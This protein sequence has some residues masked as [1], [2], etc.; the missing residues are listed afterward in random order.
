MLA[1]P[2]PR[3]GARA[4]QR[5]GTPDTPAVEQPRV[6]SEFG[7][8]PGQVDYPE[9]WNDWSGGFGYA[10]R[11]P[12]DEN[13]YFG[14][15]ANPNTYHWCENFDARFSRQLVHS[16][17]L[18]SFAV[19]LDTK[20]NEIKD[21][22]FP[23]GPDG[24]NSVMFLGDQSGVPVVG[25][26]EYAVPTGTT[27]IADRV[28]EVKF[29]MAIHTGQSGRRSAL[30][31]SFQYVPIAGGRNGFFI[32]SS[33]GGSYLQATVNMPALLFA[34]AG[35]RIWK[36]AGDMSQNT[37]A[38][39]LQSA[40]DTSPS[41]LVDPGNWSATLSIG[42]SYH[43]IKDMIAMND[44]LFV[45]KTDGLFMGD[46]TGT[47]VNVTPEL[48][49]QVNEDNGQDLCI[50]NNQVIMPHIG[51]LY[52]CNPNG[53]Q[54]VVKQV[55]PTHLS[56][57]SPIRGNFMCSRA[58]G[59]ALYGGYF[60]GT[61]S[62]VLAGYDSGNNQEYVWHPIYKIPAIAKISHIHFDGVRTNS[63]GALIASR[64]WVGAGQG[65]P[66][67]DI[68]GSIH[69]NGTISVWAAAIP[70][71]N[72]NA[73]L[74]S[75]AV[76]NPNYANSARMDLGSTDGRTPSTPKLYRQLEVWADNLDG[77]QRWGLMYYTV[78]NNTRTLL[79]TINTSPKSTLYFPSGDGSFVMGQSIELSLESYIAAGAEA[80]SPVY[81]SIILRQMQ[82]PR[83]VDVIQ[84]V[85][86]IGDNVQDRQGTRM[87][88]GAMQVNELRGL[89][90]TGPVQLV[91]IVGNTWWAKVL[92]PVEEQEEWQDGSVN[93][94][95]LA[96]IK[97]AITSFTGP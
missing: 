94:S 37:S 13:S 89:V 67:E 63:A 1:R 7:G 77:S 12:V 14:F 65:Y 53:A 79:G 18:I 36:A 19:N 80:T 42:D 15:L 82:V 70:L 25:A 35:N 16:Q 73:L 60:T 5:S 21:A 4:W 76:F 72:S 47:F 33:T 11:H 87:R 26:V 91:D 10:Y 41:N 69:A 86:D 24:A 20:L 93:P 34:V 75:D 74:P 58:L 51:G 61:Y 50:F 64:L 84:A 9:V 59:G 57:R 78:D 17:K 56:N 81:R 46:Q 85:V 49:Y 48:A 96:S 8:L 40:A 71:M 68:A 29:T 3:S 38:T 22:P 95:V 54:A 28:N 45:S 62:Y 32:L 31:G 44:Q 66:K 2:D 92:A 52:A 27:T 30:Y 23:S 6:A 83:S 55:G 39:Y 88:P 90:A 43:P 97:L